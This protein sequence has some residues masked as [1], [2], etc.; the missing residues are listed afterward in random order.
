MREPQCP[1]NSWGTVTAATLNDVYN[2]LAVSS[3]QG[4]AIPRPSPSM[5]PISEAARCAMTSLNLD[6]VVMIGHFGS[7][8]G[9]PVA[10]RCLQ[11]LQPCN[12][13]PYNCLVD[14]SISREHL[15]Q[16][17]VPGLCV[18][19]N[20]PLTFCLQPTCAVLVRDWHAV[21]AASISHQQLHVPHVAYLLSAS[22][23]LQ[24]Q[25]LFQRLKSATN[26][27]LYQAM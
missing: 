2:F 26:I 5:P 16:A 1:S 18:F 15:R 17:Q 19:A 14:C 25:A 23:H 21:S 27:N 4:A 12:I 8:S 9:L 7:K 24:M 3:Q 11:S 6:S 13:V 10:F 22:H 20:R